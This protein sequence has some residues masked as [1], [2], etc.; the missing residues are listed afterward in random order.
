ME[1]HQKFLFKI[2]LLECGKATIHENKKKVKRGDEKK[3]AKA[4]PD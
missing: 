2:D 3:K 4:H 1:S